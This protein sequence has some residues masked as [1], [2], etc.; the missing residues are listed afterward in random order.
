M[1]LDAELAKLRPDESFLRAE[2]AHLPL[3]HAPERA[4]HAAEPADRALSLAEW[5][6]Q[7]GGKK[8]PSTDGGELSAE[9]A[10][11]EG[12]NIFRRRTEATCQRS[13]FFGE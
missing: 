12:E 7:E 5:A 8:I 1:N 2:R 13:E 6:H 10:H 3:D 4:D 11:Q 9:R